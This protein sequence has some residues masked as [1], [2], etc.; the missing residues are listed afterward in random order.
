ML[1]TAKILGAEENPEDSSKIIFSEDVLRLEN[2]SIF[3]RIDHT[4]D[5]GIITFVFAGEENEYLLTSGSSFFLDRQFK[6]FR[7]NLLSCFAYT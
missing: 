2:N 1:R 4:D 3:L 7:E 6:T 5:S